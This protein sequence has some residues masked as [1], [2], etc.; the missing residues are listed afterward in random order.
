[1]SHP[2]RSLLLTFDQLAPDETPT[3]PGTVTLSQHYRQY[4]GWRSITDDYRQSADEDRKLDF[5]VVGDGPPDDVAKDAP[6]A[7]TTWSKSNWL[8]N[9]QQQ[10]QSAETANRT[11][12]VHV[13]NA[14]NYESDEVAAAVEVC[15]Q[16]S[17]ADLLLAVTGFVMHETKP[18]HTFEILADD[19]LMRVP[20]ILE[21]P[22]FSEFY[23]QTV[24]SSQD[25]LHTLLL[26]AKQRPVDLTQHQ[27]SQDEVG[28]QQW[29]LR[30]LAMNP[31]IV[32]ERNL[33]F[34]FDRFKAVRSQNFL[35]VA[36]L[37]LDG[38]SRTALREGLYVKPQDRWNVHNVCA[39][40][41]ET[42]DT[43]RKQLGL[44]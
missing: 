7:F 13:E 44:N 1:M 4:D 36:E 41:V 9:L 12:W 33:A 18:A 5:V 19:N 35:Y 25:L 34:Q 30:Q 39:E 21:H 37:D 24:T 40:Y 38:N 14:E 28:R 43:L 42:A 26:H 27:K 32:I 2:L 16:F 29:D 11:L 10:L 3:S 23:L 8:T 15:R 17:P 20:A 22:D 6:Q 31:G